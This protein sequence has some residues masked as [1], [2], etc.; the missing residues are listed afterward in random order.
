MIEEIKKA[1]HEPHESA[2]GFEKF[3]ICHHCKLLY[4][5]NFLIKCKY[6]S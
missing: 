1:S 4:P 5:E 6:T 3:D 2:R